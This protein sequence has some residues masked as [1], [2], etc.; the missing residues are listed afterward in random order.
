MQ[1]HNVLQ[2]IQKIQPPQVSQEEICQV[3]VSYQKTA[4]H[5]KIQSKIVNQ[6]PITF[7]EFMEAA[8]YDPELGFYTKGPG[9]GTQEGSFNTNAMFPAFAFAIARAIEQADR[10]VGETLRIVE[11]GGGTGEL[12]ANLVTFL[13]IPHDYVIVD[14]S[15]GLRQ[16]QKG[17]G[18]HALESADE[19]LPAP[20]FAF[21]NEVLDALPVHRVMGSAGEEL[22]ELYVDIDSNGEFI[23]I[24]DRPSTPLL[25]ERLQIEGIS[26]GR[27]QITELCLDLEPFLEKASKLMTKGYLMFIDYGEKASTLHSYFHRNGTLRSFRSQRAVFNPF[28]AV[29]DQDLTA[30]VDFTAL[31]SLA[32]NVG[33]V[34]AGHMRQGPWLKNLKIQD[35]SKFAPAQKAADQEISCLTNPARLGSTFDVALFK[36]AGLPDGIGLHP[37]S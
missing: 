29:G 24:P 4:L 30:D 34:P 28:E 16:L 12:A 35:Y 7:R 11:F 13:G 23:E 32:R 18:I 8:Q 21:G 10:L 20:T 9:I 1:S 27:G 25:A 5:R 31:N 19:L 3:N 14:I 6:G 15:P 37:L 17:R 22:F 36:T 26:L 2:K 33:L